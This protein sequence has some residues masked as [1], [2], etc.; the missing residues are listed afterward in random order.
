[1]KNST[2]H[3]LFTIIVSLFLLTPSVL[4]GQGEA[5]VDEEDEADNDLET[6]VVVEFDP[7]VAPSGVA[8][9][10]TLPCSISWAIN[11]VWW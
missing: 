6:V 3:L 8:K 1:M 11:S 2:L 9:T 10:G 5:E 7:P 4:V